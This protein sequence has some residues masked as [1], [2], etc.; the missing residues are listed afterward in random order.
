MRFFRNVALV[1]LLAGPVAA[2][3]DEP[4]RNVSVEGIGRVEAVPDMAVVQIGVQREA[5]EAGS[6]MAAA[7][8]AMTAVLAQVQDA[9]IAPGDIQTMRIGLDPRWR[10]ANDGS[11][12]RVVGYVASNDLSVTVR[13]LDLLGALLD[14]VVS[15]GANA[16]NGLSFDVADREALEDAARVAAVED[17]RRKAGMI[18]EAAES[19]LG[20]VISLSE[21]SFGGGPPIMMQTAEAMRSS[22]PVAAGQIDVVVSV[23]AVFALAD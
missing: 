19:A 11:A 21:G 14:A 9:G 7:S 13:D 1:A 6:A 8:D 12:P 23:R 5:R 15:D 2:M 20:S 22:V 3:A 16:M 4:L 18:A 10:H 17:A